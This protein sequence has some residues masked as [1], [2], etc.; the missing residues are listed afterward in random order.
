[1]SSKRKLN[2]SHDEN[3]FLTSMYEEFK[4]ILD[5]SHRDA[6]T[7]KKKNEAWEKIIS[8]HRNRF[9]HVARSREDLR[10][11]LSK[12][13]S[14]AKEVHLQQKKSQR[15]TGGGKPLPPPSEPHQKMLDLCADTP[16]FNGLVGA[17]S[18]GK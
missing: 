16:A 10:V 12:L 11:K 8:L 6:D 3:V 17:D 9:P 2:F 14:G 15:K 4:E 13:K 7:N 1:M 18:A 5:A